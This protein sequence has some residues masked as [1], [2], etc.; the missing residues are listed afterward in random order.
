ML[1][2]NNRIANY[3]KFTHTGGYHDLKRFALFFEG[4]GK[5]TD[6]RVPATSGQSGHIQHTTD[7]FSAAGNVG[8]TILFAR[9]PVV[10]SQAYQGGDLMTIELTQFGQMRQQHRT[11]MRTDAGRAAEQTIVMLQIIVGLNL[12]VDHFVEFP[13]LMFED[14]HHFSDAFADFDMMDHLRAVRFL[15]EQVA[16]LSASGD[17]IRQ[18]FDMRLSRRFRLGFDDLAELS[19]SVGVDGI[20]LGEFT[21]AASEV[22]DLS[23]IDHH[24]MVAGLEEFDGKRFFITHRLLRGRSG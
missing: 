21:Q 12:F 14:F 16:E 8:A 19:E 18:S 3:Q 9:F 22:T 1:V 20:R 24:D 2:P 15:G 7:L 17:Q 13:D 4:F 23:R 10:G 6:R 11:G 5:M